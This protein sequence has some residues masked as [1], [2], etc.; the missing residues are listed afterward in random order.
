MTN[1]HVRFG[2]K[3]DEAHTYIDI[4][5]FPLQKEVAELKPQSLDTRCKEGFDCF[6]AEGGHCR[7]S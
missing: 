6:A 5:W 4:R 3:S 1:K 7:K 2:S